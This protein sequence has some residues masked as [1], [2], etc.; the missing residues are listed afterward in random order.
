MKY[1]KIIFTIIFFCLFV[2]S[3]RTVAAQD[4]TDS[5]ATKEALP[6]RI[7]RILKEKQPEVAGALAEISTKKR[8]FVGPIERVSATSL[9]IATHKGPLVLPLDETVKVL[10][11]NKEI[12]IT[13]LSVDNFVVAIGTEIDGTFM[14]KYILSSGISEKPK[15][16]VVLLGTLTGIEKST[17]TLK[18][19]GTNETKEITVNKSTEYQNSDGSEISLKML[20]EDLTILVITTD[21]EDGLTATTIRS[22]APLSDPKKS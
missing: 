7:D 15:T 22:L 12:S 6:K 16:R 9:T 3:F 2:T 14:P 1:S 8:G 18:T 20:G 5:S 13:D 11:S 4:A 17:L 19:R 21:D 10:K